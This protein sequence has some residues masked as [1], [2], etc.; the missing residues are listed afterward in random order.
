[1]A[2]TSMARVA[3]VPVVLCLLALSGCGGDSGL[4]A[5][6]AQAFTRQQLAG[7]WK[8]TAYNPG[9]NDMVAPAPGTYDMVLK[10][11]DDG[12]FQMDEWRA[13]SHTL[14]EGWY[15]LQ[16]GGHL[17]E[18]GQL[19]FLHTDEGAQKAHRVDETIAKVS[20]DSLGLAVASGDH[21]EALLFERTPDSG[22]A[23]R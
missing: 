19:V 1:M 13:G 14:S 20:G 23:R 10:M 5:Y 2:P 12:A 21:Y 11:S 7:T 8:L 18:G 6:E 22:A 3:A 15:L 17:Q 4:N 16:E 9:D